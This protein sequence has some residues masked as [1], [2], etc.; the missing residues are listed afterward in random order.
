[1]PCPLVLVA[2]VGLVQLQAEPDSSRV[3]RLRLLALFRRNGATIGEATEQ[4]A[5]LTGAGLI[6]TPAEMQLLAN[7]LTTEGAT[8][9]LKPHISGA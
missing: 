8:V 5:R 4:T 1:M 9:S 7:R 3:L 2:R 6:G